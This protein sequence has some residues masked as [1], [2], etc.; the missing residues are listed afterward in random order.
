MTQYIYPFWLITL[1]RCQNWHTPCR[2]LSNG[3][4]IWNVRILCGSGLLKVSGFCE[5]N[6]K[7]HIMTAYRGSRSE[8]R[9]F[10]ECG[11][12]VS[13]TLRLLHLRDSL[14]RKLLF[15]EGKVKWTCSAFVRA[16]VKHIVMNVRQQCLSWANFLSSYFVASEWTG[17]LITITISCHFTPSSGTPHPTNWYFCY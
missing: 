16:P 14:C 6:N 9:N 7:C 2:R 3:T 4:D 11:W 15:G 10:L 13:F 12:A 1:Y 8:A 17:K 5:S